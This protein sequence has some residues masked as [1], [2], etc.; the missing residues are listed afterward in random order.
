MRRA[1]LILATVAALLLVFA[2]PAAAAPPIR[3]S[4][5]V[6]FASAYS[7]D[8]EQQRGSTVCTDTYLSVQE[9]P[10][11][12][13]ACVSVVT[14]SISSSGRYRA[15]SE[16]SGCGDVA[17]DAFTIS[18]GLASATLAPTAIELYSCN[19][20]TCTSGGIVTVSGEFTGTGD[21]NRY[22]GRGSFTE[23][24]CRYRYSFDG[25]SR[26]ALAT[27]TVD[28]TTSTGEGVIGEE[29]YTFTVNCR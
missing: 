2:Q 22:S 8:C 26:Q 27:I 10:D 4:G 3:E 7:S 16:E 18:S 29:N 12:A 6:A 21:V 25:A 13:I 28:G 11:G 1:I 5:S 17:P 15:I 14:Y 20:R 24:A 9:T 19:R 23:G